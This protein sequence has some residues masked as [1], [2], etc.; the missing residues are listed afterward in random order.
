VLTATSNGSGGSNIAMSAAHRSDL[1]R[2][3]SDQNN[4]VHVRRCI[5]RLGY[6]Y[7]DGAMA[8]GGF[9]GT[10]SNLDTF[11]KGIWMANDI[12]GGWPQF[13]VPVQTHGKS[14]MAATAVDLANV[15]TAMHRGTL[16]DSNKSRE[17]MNIFSRGGSWLQ[18]VPN[19]VRLGI[20]SRG[21]KVGHAPSDDA[22]V[23]TVKSEAAF[24]DR[25]GVLFAAV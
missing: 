15:L 25:G 2:V 23:P 11:K 19:S 8:A 21:A 14:S 22:H 9:L 13:F 16:I 7:V 17:M 4:N 1:E 24:L 5:R 3:F 18:M 6:S 20:I 12:G 10:D